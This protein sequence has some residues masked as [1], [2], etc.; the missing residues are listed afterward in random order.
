MIMGS[1][2]VDD[3]RHRDLAAGFGRNADRG[4]IEA[5][6]QLVALDAAGRQPI[7]GIG[8]R[9]TRRSRNV[10]SERRTISWLVKP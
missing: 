1:S 8:A 10:P 9:R 6:D 4:V 2:C 7:A 5:Q 3:V